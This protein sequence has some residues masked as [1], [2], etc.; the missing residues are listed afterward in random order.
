[1]T[2]NGSLGNPWATIAH[3]STLVGPGATVYV[4]AGVYDASFTTRASGTA[5]AYITYQATSADFSVNVNC[6]QLAA[7]HGD[8][9]GCPQLVGTNTDT[10]ENTGNYVAIKGF[11]VTGPGINGIYTQGNA[12]LIQGNHV[13][14]VLTSTCNSDGGSGINLNGTNAEVVGNYVHN[15]GPFPAPC[16]FVQGIYFLQAG[17]YAF[18]NIS[19][20]N[21]G[22]GIQL[23]HYP[24]NVA[25]FNNTVFNNASGGIVLG[26]DN[27]FTVDYITVANNIVVNNN[28]PGISEQGA[29][30]TSTGKHNVY[31]NNL[32][33]QN[34]GGSIQLQNGLTAKATLVSSPQ[35]VN[36][37]GTATGIYQLLESSPALNA[38]IVSGAPTNDFNGNPR[39]QGQAPD[40][41]AYQRAA[42]IE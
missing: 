36:Y 25:I 22:F 9:S 35:F 18:N 28:G 2:G 40:L 23:W 19:F 4:A 32:V 38:G 5:G 34:A 37:T 26:T 1:M 33:D 6:A 39:P 21:S 20:A 8:L 13:H 17:G 16:G 31:E 27:S 14:D 30:A 41:G 3:A 10:W 29:S 24:A 7:Q 15:I 42:S 12:T 11:D